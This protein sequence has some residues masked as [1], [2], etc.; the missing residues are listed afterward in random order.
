MENIR[1]IVKQLLHE[2]PSTREDDQL[3]H[4]LVLEKMGYA[5][6]V[7]NGIFIP[8]KHIADHP[9]YES[10]SRERRLQQQQE[11]ENQKNKNKWMIQPKKIIRKLRQQEEA[12]MHMIHSW[13]EFRVNPYQP[14]TLLIPTEE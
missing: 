5:H 9:V 13:N 14:Q 8:Y 6:R 7:K 12:K 11:R 2:K 3:I 10:I 4:Y 1:D